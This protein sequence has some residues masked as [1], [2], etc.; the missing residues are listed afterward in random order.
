[1]SDIETRL[2]ALETLLNINSSSGPY[3]ENL[4]VKGSISLTDSESETND[5]MYSRCMQVNHPDF[6]NGDYTNYNNRGTICT[7]LVNTHGAPV[8]Y[9]QE[10][11]NEALAYIRKSNCVSSSKTTEE[12]M[13]NCMYLNNTKFKLSTG[14]NGAKIV[15]NKQ[16]DIY[17]YNPSSDDKGSLNMSIGHSL[18][19]DFKGTIIENVKF[20]PFS[21]IK[22]PSETSPKIL[23]LGSIHASKLFLNSVGKS[24][25]N[26]GE[27]DRVEKSP[28]HFTWGVINPETGKK[29]MANPTCRSGINS[30][31]GFTCVSIDHTGGLNNLPD[32]ICHGGQ[33]GCDWTVHTETECGNLCK[34]PTYISK[35]Y[36]QAVRGTQNCDG[37]LKESNTNWSTKICTIFDDERTKY[38]HP[39]TIVMVNSGYAGRAYSEWSYIN[40]GGSGFF[41]GSPE[42]WFTGFGSGFLASPPWSWGEVLLG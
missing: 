38:S 32:A 3:I 16:L 40:S 12:N 19:D 23:P 25:N 17:T 34:D 24:S 33:G 1:M 36:Q 6:F 18:D 22:E 9:N 4:N 42:S 41:G 20:S 14:K 21:F 5:R 28:I 31:G 13:N 7:Q 29:Y 26:V 30:A 8:S 2:N 37:W 35:T 39:N 11:A 10:Y 27:D 15:S